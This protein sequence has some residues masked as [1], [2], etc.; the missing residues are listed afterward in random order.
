MTLFF[1]S[2]SPPILFARV[3]VAQARSLEAPGARLLDSR[4][5]SRPAYRRSWRR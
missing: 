2:A 3:L 4:R 5:L 1:R